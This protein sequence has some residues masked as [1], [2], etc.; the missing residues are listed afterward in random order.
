MLGLGFKPK[1]KVVALAFNNKSA[2]RAGPWAPCFRG[3]HIPKHQYTDRHSVW[4]SS[5]T[6]GLGPANGRGGPDHG[7]IETLSI[8]ATV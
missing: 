4:A 8:S 1:I 5:G 7:F 2:L 3:S 6:L